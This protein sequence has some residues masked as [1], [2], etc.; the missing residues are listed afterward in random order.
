MDR[1]RVTRAV[2]RLEAR[3]LVSKL[4]EK[5]IQLSK[6]SDDDPDSARLQELESLLESKR[7]REEELSILLQKLDARV[8]DQEIMLEKQQILIDKLLSESGLK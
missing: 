3:D 5:I 8:R 2:Q 7:K 4:E 1:A 6:Q